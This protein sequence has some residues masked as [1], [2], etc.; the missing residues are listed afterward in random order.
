MLKTANYIGELVN[1]VK[2]R[3]TLA[4]KVLYEQYSKSMLT[5]SY[6]ITNNLEDAEDIIQEAFLKSFQDI[7]KLKEVNKYGAWLKRIII[8]TSL[9]KIKGKVRFESIEN[10][11]EPEDQVEEDWYEGIPLEKIRTAIQALPDGCRQI[12]TLYLMEDY[13]HREIGEMLN[14]SISTSKS[15]YR[16]ALQLLKHKLSNNQK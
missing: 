16:Y 8:N 6:R 10:V 7:H 11:P 13:K 3:D 5:I 2:N 12:F 14:I 4:M 9:N 15:Q 1:R